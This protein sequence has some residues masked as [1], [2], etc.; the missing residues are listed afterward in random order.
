MTPAEWIL[1]LSI[2][3]AGYLLVGYPLL[4]RFF[5][6]RRRP[7]RKDLNH[8]PTVTVLM[9]VHNGAAFL[10]A[11]LQN[12]LSLDYPREHMDF[13]V[14]SDGSTDD[15]EA[16]A[17]RF[18]GAGFRLLCVPRGGKAAAVNAGLELATGDVVMFCDVRQL[19]RH[20]TLRHLVANFADPAVGAVTG[21]LQILAPSSGSGEQADL[22]VYWRYELW[23]RRIQSEIWSL[24]NV[25]GCMYAM[26]RNLIKRMMPG[27]LADDIAMPIVAYQ[28][29]Y[30]VVAEPD[31]VAT[32]YPTQEG[33]EFRR[34]MRTLS[35]AWQV[36]VR[37]PGL[38]FTPHRMWLHFVSHKLGRL[39]LPWVLVSAVISS[40]LLPEGSGKVLV[41]LAEAG[42]VVMALANPWIP[43]TFPGKR[44][45]SLASTFLTMNLA[46]LLS[47]Q[48]F[49]VPAARLWTRPTAVD[50]VPHQ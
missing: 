35:G 41:L 39:L 2:A 10:D 33:G 21:E 48:I 7:V 5:P 28:R 11:K 43:S 16:I 15:T 47:I 38:L 44:V 12:L 25:T 1:F 14:V 20:D 24:F 31:A 29:G 13:I 17:A 9:A 3:S 26:R 6:F 32:D 23:A 46:A 8:T 18:A 22:G 19:F 37:Q 49:F 36:W 30:R 40:F 27:T 34:R 42:L 45:T 50:Q 4:L